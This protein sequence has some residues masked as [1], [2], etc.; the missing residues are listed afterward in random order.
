VR[1]RWTPT[2]LEYLQRMYK[3]QPINTTV[4][5]VNQRGPH[6][7]RHAIEAQAYKRG[8]TGAHLPRGYTILAEAHYRQGANPQASETILRAAKRDGVL[9]RH[10]MYP[11]SPWIAPTEWVEQ[12]LEQ[13][14]AHKQEF[15]HVTRTW[16][17][18]RVIAEALGIRPGDIG[19]RRAA[20]TPLGRD[21]RQCRTQRVTFEPGQ[22]N[23]WHP[24]DVQ[25]LL[26]RHGVRRA[27]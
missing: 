22:P 17:R 2:Q 6:K 16:V 1:K 8:L 15:E 26:A 7:T 11:G 20:N 5:G 13:R 27:A 12:W 23:Y 10:H 9:R 18:T 21:L 24:Q 14:Y 25:W 3:R 19:N 4:D